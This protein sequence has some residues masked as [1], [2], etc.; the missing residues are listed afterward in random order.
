MSDL[1]GADCRA[2][3]EGVEAAGGSPVAA[4]HS[5][6]VPDLGSSRWGLLAWEDPW[7]RSGAVP[8]WGGVPM[9]DAQNV[10]R[11]GFSVLGD[12]ARIGKDLCGPS[13]WR[14]GTHCQVWN[15]LNIEEPIGTA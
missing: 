2:Q 7:V 13:A 10:Q 1:P 4:A 15:V 5:Q 8:F 11:V 6:S 12:G 3:R 14:R 9:L